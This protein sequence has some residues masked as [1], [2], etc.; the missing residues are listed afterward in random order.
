MKFIKY[1]LPLF[2]FVVTLSSFSF[3]CARSSVTRI[4]SDPIAA[5]PSASEVL[6]FSQESEIKTPFITVGLINYNNPGKYQ[7][8]TLE[9]AIPDLKIQARSV[10]ANAIIIDQSAPVKSGLIS[11]GITVKARAIKIQ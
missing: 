10:G 7:I 5:A 4:G 1:Y 6:V 11:T 9:D 2:L 3:G 8:L